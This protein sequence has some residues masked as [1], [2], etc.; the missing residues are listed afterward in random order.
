MLRFSDLEN[1]DLRVNKPIEMTVE[2]PFHILSCKATPA[3]I[4]VPAYEM[5]RKDPIRRAQTCECA[6]PGSDPSGSKSSEQDF[7]THQPINSH[8]VNLLPPNGSTPP[9]ESSTNGSG[10]KSSDIRRPPRAYLGETRRDDSRSLPIFCPI[11]SAQS[12]LKILSCRPVN[13]FP[14]IM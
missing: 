11:S 8:H 10:T 14:T 12:N 13:E 9:F 6:C 7:N 5:N 1:G 3:N 4:F 2:S